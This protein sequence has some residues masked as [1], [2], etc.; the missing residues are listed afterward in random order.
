VSVR[1][2]SLGGASID[3]AVRRSGEAVTV[4]MKRSTG[5][6]QLALVMDDGRTG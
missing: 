1:N 5:D 3:F 2:L 4:D 6:L